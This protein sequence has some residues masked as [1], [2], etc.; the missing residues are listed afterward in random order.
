MNVC[1]GMMISC[2]E[3]HSSHICLL[4]HFVTSAVVWRNVSAFR[5]LWFSLSQSGL[6]DL[7]GLQR[8]APPQGGAPDQCRRQR[9]PPSLHPRSAGVC[10]CGQTVCGHMEGGGADSRSSWRLN[11]CWGLNRRRGSTGC[12]SAG[13][14][15]ED[16]SGTSRSPFIRHMLLT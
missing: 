5:I 2:E 14:L 7:K 4:W 15:I 10:L 6:Q 13:M 9:H 3:K 11:W 8:S 1:S 16:V 12:V